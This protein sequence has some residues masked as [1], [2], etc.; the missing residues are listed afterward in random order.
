[1]YNK[2]VVMRGNYLDKNYYVGFIANKFHLVVYGDRG[3]NP[4]EMEIFNF[5]ID[6]ID[7][8]IKE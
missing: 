4:Q 6:Y 8:L 5:V 7:K 2:K 3:F 1:M